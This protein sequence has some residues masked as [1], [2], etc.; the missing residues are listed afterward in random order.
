[1]SLISGNV[2]SIS[3]LFL[4]SGALL[5]AGCDSDSSPTSPGSN[6]ETTISGRVTDDAGFAKR[7]DVEDAEVRAEEVDDDG[8]MRPADGQTTTDENGAYTLETDADARIMVVTAEKGSFE[9]RTLVVRQ[10]GEDE[11]SAME[12]NAETRAEA[13]V[14]AEAKQQDSDEEPVTPGD[15]A[16]HV[17]ARTAAEI[18][19]NNASDAQVAAAVRAAAEAEMRYLAESGSA[20]SEQ[21]SGSVENKTNAFIQLQSALTAG[22]DASAAMDAFSSSMSNAYVDAGIDEHA[23]A[24]ARQTAALVIQNLSS[25]LSENARF[26]LRQ[27]AELLAATSTSAAVES[28]FAAE[29]GLETEAAAVASAGADLRESI[30]SASSEAEI[31]AAWASFESETM[32]QLSAGISLGST[33]LATVESSLAALRADFENSISGATSVDAF[34]QAKSTFHSDAR[35]EIEGDLSATANA[36]FAARVITLVSAH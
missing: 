23:N 12:M 32:S 11:L 13:R 29:T 35:S 10:A 2:K 28:Q 36:E 20:T 3:M 6:G 14:Y 5:V 34:V 33:L 4:V 18:E 19:S 16:L 26:A 25:G 15:V 30:A 22:A 27:H 31:N 24:E 7:A 9:S 17:D 21:M 1:M 8:T